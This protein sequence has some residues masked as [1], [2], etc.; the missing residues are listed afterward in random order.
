[1]TSGDVGAA[2]ALELAGD[3]IVTVDEKGSITSWNRLAE[4]VLGFT[5]EEAVGATLA[6]IV[7]EEHRARHVAAFHRAMDTGRLAHQGRP[8]KVVGTRKDGERIDLVMSL[9][10]LESDGLRTGAVAVLRAAEPTPDSFV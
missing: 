3:V 1:M 7:P 4:S 10:L 5:S 6:L 2:E 9:G 8:S